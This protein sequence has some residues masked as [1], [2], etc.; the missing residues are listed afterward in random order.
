M[1]D[2]RIGVI[3]DAMLMGYGVFMAEAQIRELLSAL[4]KVGPPLPNAQT[5]TL[6]APRDPECSRFILEFVADMQQRSQP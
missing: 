4:D 2:Q 6:D 1:C 3:R 5:I